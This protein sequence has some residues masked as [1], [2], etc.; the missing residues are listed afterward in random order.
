MNKID[1]YLESVYKNFNGNKD[2]LVSL[3]AEMKS[4][5]LEEVNELKKSG[6]DEDESLAMA[7]ENFG[8]PDELVRE[9]S[10]EYRIEKYKPIKVLLVLILSLIVF[11]PIYTLL[12]LGDDKMTFESRI[13]YITVVP[14]YLI[15]EL[16][17]I[18]SYNKNSINI[19]IKYEILKSFFIIV[20]LIIVADIIFPINSYKSL[21]DIGSLRY[22]Q[23]FD[24]LRFFNIY[25]LVL[26]LKFII[27]GYLSS[28]IFQTD[29]FKKVISLSLLVPILYILTNV[30][31]SF[32]GFSDG[33]RR[34]IAAHIIV[35]IVGVFIGNSLYTNKFITN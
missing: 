22:V 11:L 8:S 5:I 9:L 4:H 19:N 32:S 20:S 13:I 24:N 31:I 23:L 29:N 6:Y 30:I 33:F 10:I 2:E 15:Y 14:A 16:I 7:L 18:N 27:L 34:I 35:Y 28:Y 26:L 17:L 21:E 3:K 1:N 12:F 25:T